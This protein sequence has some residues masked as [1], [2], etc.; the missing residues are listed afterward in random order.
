MSGSVGVSCAKR[1]RRFER[2]KKGSWDDLTVELN[3]AS[4]SQGLIRISTYWSSIDDS[5]GS[6]RLIKF[7]VI[8][9]YGSA[10]GGVKRW[11]CTG[12]PK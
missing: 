11:S 2:A 9:R 4:N 8:L 1:V 6:A 5:S 10:Y 7:L 3:K 12:A